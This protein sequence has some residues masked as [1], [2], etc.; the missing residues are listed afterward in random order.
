MGPYYSLYKNENL[1]LTRTDDS[2]LE[3]MVEVLN[4]VESQFVSRKCLS[5]LDGS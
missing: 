1:K 3:R 4:E 5:F 2:G